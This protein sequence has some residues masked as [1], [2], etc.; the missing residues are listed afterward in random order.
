[1]EASHEPKHDCLNM[2]TRSFISLVGISSDNWVN[3]DALILE[4]IQRV[5]D[6]NEPST[7]FFFTI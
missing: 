6:E 5:L 7:H 2:I 1:M 4:D 3:K